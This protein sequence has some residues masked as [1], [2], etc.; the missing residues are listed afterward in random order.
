MKFLILTLP[1]TGSKFLQENLAQ[2]LCDNHSNAMY[3]KKDPFGR[4]FPFLQ[5]IL[6]PTHIELRQGLAYRDEYR[7]SFKFNTAY[8]AYAHTNAD[9][10]LL[11]QYDEFCRRIDLLDCEYPW[12]VKFFAEFLN[13]N[14]IGL[15]INRLMP[16]TDRIFILNRNHFDAVMSH[17]IASRFMSFGS[18]EKQRM[19]IDALTEN[20]IELDETRFVQAYKRFL[21]FYEGVVPLVMDRYGKK[22]TIVEYSILEKIDNQKDFL[23]YLNIPY[24]DFALQNPGKEYG[25]DK[26]KLITNVD[27][28]RKVCLEKRE[29]LKQSIEPLIRELKSLTSILP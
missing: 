15:L 14:Y 26:S 16:I 28:L 13:A 23:E 29:T 27:S 19:I 12:V 11:E 4:F 6:N 21:F 1:R 8:K 3:I 25:P 2:Y 24:A 9:Q 17:Q 18:G 20:P 5:E 7:V 22:V 10:V